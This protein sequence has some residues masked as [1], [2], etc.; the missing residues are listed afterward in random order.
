M[1][2]VSMALSRFK[3]WVYSKLISLGS[4]PVTL[5][6]SPMPPNCIPSLFSLASRQNAAAILKWLNWLF[7]WSWPDSNYLTSR[8]YSFATQAPWSFSPLIGLRRPWVER[9]GRVVGQPSRSL[10]LGFADYACLLA[11]SSWVSCNRVGCL[12]HHA[13][14]RQCSTTSHV[15]FSSSQRQGSLWAC[16]SYLHAW[17]TDSVRNSAHGSSFDHLSIDLLSVISL[18]RSESRSCC[19]LHE[20]LQNAQYHQSSPFCLFSVFWLSF[21]ELLESKPCSRF[22]R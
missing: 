5:Y 13:R 9:V 21:C 3:D 19:Q 22:P 18:V 12:D 20:D 17:C 2:R 10:R 1:W 14:Y 6:L 11:L 8:R 7:A 15:A 16:E 4:L